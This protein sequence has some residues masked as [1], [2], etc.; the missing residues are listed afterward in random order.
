MG[1]FRRDNNK[2]ERHKPDPELV[3]AK[4][5][6]DEVTIRATVAVNELTERHRRNH[7]TELAASIFRGK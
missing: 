6:V 1:F 3:V 2:H 5:R 7:F 4:R